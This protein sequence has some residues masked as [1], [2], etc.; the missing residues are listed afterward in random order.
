MFLRD[1]LL[2]IVWISCNRGSRR[3]CFK[4][5]SSFLESKQLILC[6]NNTRLKKKRLNIDFE[7]MDVVESCMTLCIHMRLRE[8]W[9]QDTF[10]HKTRFSLVGSYQVSTSVLLINHLIL[11]RLIQPHISTNKNS[12]QL[13]MSVLVTDALQKRINSHFLTASQS[14]CRWS[15]KDIQTNLLFYF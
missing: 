2:R 12:S 3:V 13:R 1:S 8:L 11:K 14:V 15:S 5:K 10:H 6:Y 7:S 9:F 4:L